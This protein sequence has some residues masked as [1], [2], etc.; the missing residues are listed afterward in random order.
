MEML[1]NISICCLIN[2]TDNHNLV[3]CL[4]PE[5]NKTYIILVNHLKKWYV[6]IFYGTCYIN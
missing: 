6:F 4:L 5:E 1:N 3:T 2:C